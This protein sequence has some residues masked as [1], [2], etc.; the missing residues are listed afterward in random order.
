[1][2]GPNGLPIRNQ[3]R[4]KTAGH[5]NNTRQRKKAAL[6][7]AQQARQHDTGMDYIVSKS[8]AHLGAGIAS[9]AGVPTV[10]Y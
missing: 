1:M 8:T 5:G 10:N 2:H 4:N 9:S 7:A 6:A 3:R